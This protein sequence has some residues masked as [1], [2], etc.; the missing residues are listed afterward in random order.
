MTKQRSDYRAYLLRLWRSR[1][2]GQMTWDASLESAETR[3]IDRFASL[4]DL[5]DF[6]R[7]ETD[8]APGPGQVGPSD[9]GDCR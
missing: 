8:A 6:L 9:A 5:F 4:D 7:Q 2:W 1:R 3:E